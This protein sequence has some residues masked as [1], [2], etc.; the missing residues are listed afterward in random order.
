MIEF[1]E[2][3]TGYLQTNEWPF[4]I[5]DAMLIFL[6]LIIFNIIH[7][8]RCLVNDSTDPVVNSSALN[9]LEMNGTSVIATDTVKPTESVRL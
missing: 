8:S 9:Q 2:N 5:F 3:A 6:A 4:Y 7:P 1:S